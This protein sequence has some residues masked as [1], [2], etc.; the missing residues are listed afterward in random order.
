MF[1][2]FFTGESNYSKAFLELLE[3][4]ANPAE[5]LIVFGFA[6][7]Q[8]KGIRYSEKLAGR[9]KYLTKA[10]DLLYVVK[11]LPS[12]DWIYLHYLAYDPSLL[13]WS[14]NKSLVQRSTWVVWGNDIYSYYKRNKNL[15]TR[16][17]EV[18]RKRII[19][20][21]TEIAAFVEEDYD[22]IKKLYTTRAGYIP[23]LYPI[24]VN[25]EHLDAAKATSSSECPVFLIGNSGD[26]S[27]LHLEM[28]D[29]LG[30]FSTEEFIVKCP[31]SYGAGVNY[32]AKVIEHGRKVLG[33]KFVPVTEF[34]DA[35][36]YARLL[37]G[38]DVALMNHRR[39]QGL[40]NIM[41]LMYLGRKVYLRSDIS[42]YYYF[43][44]NK[45]EVYAIET[46][47]T[48]SYEEL[49]RPVEDAEHTIPLISELLSF[50]NYKQLWSHLL[51]KHIS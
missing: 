15:K 22:L 11:H 51:N 17:Y 6:R 45:L 21:F 18:L 5:H 19:S 36:A 41:A 30:R 26:P 4:I 7:R 47:P 34:M 29:Y 2:H 23:I 48:L 37:A 13:Y 10:G 9:I 12:A 3:K 33:D 39:Q 1:Y 46:I 50:T 8:N 20:N 16:I 24:P 14:L 32:Q 27:N 38:V 40:G 42:S 25:T 28:I 43:R 49:V 44:R 35:E 31:L